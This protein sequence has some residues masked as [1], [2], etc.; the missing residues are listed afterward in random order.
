MIPITYPGIVPTW[1]N[2]YF[3]QIPPQIQEISI[4]SFFDSVAE[5]KK[6]MFLALFSLKIFRLFQISTLSRPTLSRSW[7]IHC[8]LV[9]R[10]KKKNPPRNRTPDP[11]RDMSGG[12]QTSFRLVKFRRTSLHK[13]SK[14]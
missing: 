12:L 10:M 5:V 3:G 6:L 8:L 7:C 9:V 11:F 2:I 4:F 1:I 13:I 14:N